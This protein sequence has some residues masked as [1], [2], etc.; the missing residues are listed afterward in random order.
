[1]K[2]WKTTIFGLVVIG[3]IIFKAWKP[4][5]AGA[6]DQVIA[7]LTGLG[8]IAAKDYNVSSQERN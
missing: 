4:Q 3:T 2:S 5:Y 8:L 1:V 6:C 7:T